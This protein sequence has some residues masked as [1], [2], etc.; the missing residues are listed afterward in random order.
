MC[1]TISCPQAVAKQPAETPRSYCSDT[2]N[3]R[4]AVANSRVT[5]KPVNC[6]FFQYIILKCKLADRFHY[7]WKELSSLSLHFLLS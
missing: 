2:R 1:Q 6:H 3:H 7:F 4:G 5:V